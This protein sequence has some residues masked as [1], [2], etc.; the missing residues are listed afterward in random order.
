[1]VALQEGNPEI[2]LAIARDILRYFL[3][4]PKAADD[5]EGIVRFRLINEQIHRNV[6]ESRA[7]LDWLVSKGL[8]VQEKA[9]TRNPIYRL[10]P[11]SRDAV[12]HFLERLGGF[13]K[14]PPQE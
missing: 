8:L 3:R 10:N 9:G 2:D 12:E 6:S 1:M 5:L 13:T 4:N 11:A 7:T 14:A